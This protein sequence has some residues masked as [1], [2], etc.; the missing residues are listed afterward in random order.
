MQTF[1]VGDLVVLDG[2]GWDQVPE[3]GQVVTIERVMHTAFA[4]ALNGNLG[5]FHLGGEEWF[6]WSEEGHPFHGTIINEPSHSG[7][8]KESTSS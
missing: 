4:E 8:E 2:T 3:Q 1:S 5:A 7:T 6:V